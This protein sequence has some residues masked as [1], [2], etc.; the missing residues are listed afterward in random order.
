MIYYEHSITIRNSAF[1]DAKRLENEFWGFPTLRTYIFLNPPL[2]DIRDMNF[3]YPRSSMT[4][5]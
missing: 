2:S 3:G 1:G 5:A 4:P